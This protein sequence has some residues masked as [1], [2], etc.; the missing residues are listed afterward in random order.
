MYSA[1]ISNSRMIKNTIL[2]S[3][4]IYVA[5]ILQIKL[6]EQQIPVPTELVLVLEEIYRTGLSFGMGQEEHMLSHMKDLMTLDY[7]EWSSVA[8]VV[9][10][11]KQKY[12]L[13]V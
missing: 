8:V 13:K 10:F 7:S 2:A 9:P 6:K 12:K 3:F 1:C 4:R 11:P 5:M